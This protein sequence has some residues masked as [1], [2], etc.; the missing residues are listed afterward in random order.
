[1]SPERE[2]PKTTQERENP[3]PRLF[4]IV[5]PD[6][7]RYLSELEQTLNERGLFVSNVYFVQDWETTARTIYERQLQT[8]SRSFCVGFESHIWLCRYLFGNQ[9]L[10]L[11]FDTEAAGLSLDSQAQALYEARNCFRSKFSASDDTFV[12]AVNLDKFPGEAFRGSGKKK[13]H[14]GI[15]QPNSFTPLIER[16]SRGRWYGNYFKYIHAPENFDELCFQFK[17]L[18]ELGILKEENR[19]E[20]EEWEKLKFM[21]CL[22][23]PS[24]YRKSD[25]T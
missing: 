3:G 22:T 18:T 9:A 20:K 16:E 21:H 15:S 14:L 17:A 5:K 8:S 13:G 1:M 23:P 10:L 6:G 12:I 2:L 7:S 25:I 24:R 4:V 19:I 11:L